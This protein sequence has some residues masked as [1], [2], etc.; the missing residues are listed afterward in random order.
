MWA[1]IESRAASEAFREAGLWLAVPGVVD[2]AAVDIEGGRVAELPLSASV[3]R[4]ASACVAR[5]FFVGVSAGSGH[6]RF[7]AGVTGSA[8][9]DVEAEDGG[10]GGTVPGVATE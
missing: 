3:A 2:E 1:T 10:L 7:R 4:S 5:G 9:A 8:E 6:G